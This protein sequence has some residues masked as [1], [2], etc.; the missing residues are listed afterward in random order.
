MT[1]G[2]AVWVRF[3]NNTTPLVAAA[4]A[5]PIEDIVVC[6]L[7]AL[8]DTGNALAAERDPWEEEEATWGSSL[9]LPLV[10]R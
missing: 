9:F 3:G 1:P 4:D 7:P 10:Q 2:H 6:D 5:T 8:D